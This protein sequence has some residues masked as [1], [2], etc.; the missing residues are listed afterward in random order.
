MLVLVY[1]LKVE[2]HTFLNCG[3][4]ELDVTDKLKNITSI[5]YGAF[6]ECNGVTGE[7]NMPNLQGTLYSY[8]FTNTGIT[9][10]ISL[11]EITSIVSNEN[12]NSPFKGTRLTDVILSD[13]ITEITQDSLFANI[14][15]LKN[16]NIPHNL[17]SLPTRMFYNCTGLT[18]IQIPEAVTSIGSACFSGC[19]NLE[20]DLSSFD[21]NITTLNDSCFF[22]CS[23]VYGEI[24]LPNLAG[25]L[26]SQAFHSTL[27]TKVNDL[28][29]VN[30]VGYACFA[31][32]LN[33]K[34][35]VFPETVTY[36]DNHMLR[37][38]ENYVV[39]IF[40]SA[41]PCTIGK[42]FFVGFKGT[43]KIYVPDD[44]VEAYRQASTWINWATKIFPISEYVE[45]EEDEITE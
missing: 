35:I 21:F 7:L 38:N 45:G 13:T 44:S 31:E 24:N 15:T 30:N 33:L 39:L 6:A 40:K 2:H 41:V 8:T 26:G 4:L 42:D 37:A 28:G 23:K 19:S 29:T 34:K 17:K 27:I 22:K 43:Y 18:S 10:I 12:N 11:G 36:V 1:V 5:G 16:V 14:A 3:S 20:F 32:C 9:K 25:R